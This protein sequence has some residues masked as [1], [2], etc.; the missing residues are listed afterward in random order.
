MRAFRRTLA[1]VLLSC[2]VFASPAAAA[3]PGWDHAGYDAE[4][5]YYNPGESAINATTIGHLTRRWSVPLRQFPAACGGPSTPL[6]AA[7]L[8]I[9][10]DQ[11]G[12]STYHATTGRLAWRFDWPDPEDSS[13][14]TMAVSENVLVLGNGDCHSAS[15]PDGALTALDLTTGRVRWR[16]TPPV[17]VNAFVVDKGTVV[18]S[19]GSESDETVT[20]AY[21]AT[22]GRKLW[23]K[24]GYETSG[25]SAA[26]RILLTKD[27]ST[28]AVSVL[29][30]ATTWTK[31][32]LWQA[33]SATPAGDRFLVTNGTALSLV[34]AA[35]GALL[36]TAPGQQS[37]QLATDGR[38]IYRAVDSAVSA[39]DIRDG[40]VVWTR[41]LP[42]TATQPVRA[43]GLLYTGGPALSASS[44]AVVSRAFRGPQI[45][46]GGRLYVVDSNTLN[47][48][49]PRQAEG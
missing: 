5:S 22:D 37:T 12:V 7:G 32:R 27:T 44:G 29:T 31:P 38:R 20:V 6:V 42:L 36:W 39:L 33:Q 35:S 14:P 15:D 16:L 28:S 49:G 1:S 23:S 18:I 19:G 45:I 43:G 25:V 11:K 10:T 8:V 21:R 3:T 17:P 41:T 30:G 2:L 46:A 4:D 48:F 34:N 26:G 40:R 24:P 47:T 13:T 9:A